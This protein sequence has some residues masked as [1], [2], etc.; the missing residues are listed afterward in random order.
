MHCRHGSRAP[1]HS[2]TLLETHEAHT[3][4]LAPAARNRDDRLRQWGGHCRIPRSHNPKDPRGPKWA[5]VHKAPTG[6]G[7]GWAPPRLREVCLVVAAFSGLG[8]GVR[9]HAAAAAAFAMS[10]GA[11]FLFDFV[12]W[13]WFVLVSCPL[14]L[15]PPAAPSSL[16]PPAAPAPPACCPRP[17]GRGGRGQGE[18][19]NRWG[20]G[21]VGNPKPKQTR[22]TSLGSTNSEIY[23]S[24]VFSSSSSWSASASS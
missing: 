17:P 4:A 24:I 14:P 23:C 22:R 9:V 1:P 6:A 11:S 12:H 19:G 16:L 10:L 8:V 20:W 7:D 15:P 13:F 21:V 5:K 18:V 2:P 3:L